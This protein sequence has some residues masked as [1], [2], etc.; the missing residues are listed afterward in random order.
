MITVIITIGS[1]QKVEH[2]CDNAVRSGLRNPSN[3]NNNQ[4]EIGTDNK[5][6]V[7]NLSKTKLTEA[8]ESLLAKGPNSAITPVNIPHVDYITAIESVCPKLKEEDTMEL[9]ADINSLLRR[10]KIPKAN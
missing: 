8:Q 1:E 6:R 9:K 5:K 7:I 10:A 4:P 2:T 3:N